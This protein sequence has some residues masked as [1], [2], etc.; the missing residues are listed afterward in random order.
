MRRIPLLASVLVLLAVGAMI[1]L[2]LWQ[3]RRAE[4]KEVLVTRAA[5]NLIEPAVDLPARLTPG[6]AYLRF[7]VVFDS[8]VFDRGLSSGTGRACIPAWLQQAICL[9]L[10]V[11]DPFPLLFAFTLHLSFR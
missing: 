9:L 10:S 11:P 5:Q 7:L 1:A 4:S 3:L 2:G 8:L 6:P